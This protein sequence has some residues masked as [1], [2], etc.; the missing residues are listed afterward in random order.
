MSGDFEGG[1]SLRK[2]FDPDRM[3]MGRSR[4]NPYVSDIADLISF[5]PG[6]M[7][8]RKVLRS[9]TVRTLQDG[10]ALFSLLQNIRDEGSGNTVFSTRK[11]PMS[12]VK[13]R[14]RSSPEIDNIIRLTQ[15]FPKQSNI[16]AVP[17]VPSPVDPNPLR[18][19]RDAFI[20]LM[21]GRTPEG[22][23]GRGVQET[24][25][26]G[27]LSDFITR[28]DYMHDES[29]YY[30]GRNDELDPFIEG[31]SALVSGDGQRD[32]Y[33]AVED[34]TFPASAAPSMSGGTLYD[35][36]GDVKIR[37]TM[38]EVQQRLSRH[39]TNVAAPFASH[40]GRP[41]WESHYPNNPELWFPN[42]SR[43]GFGA[44]YDDY[45]GSVLENEGARYMLEE[46]APFYGTWLPQVSWEAEGGPTVTERS[47]TNPES[48]MQ[49]VPRKHMMG[50]YETLLNPV[51]LSGKAQI[52]QALLNNLNRYASQSMRDDIKGSAR[53]FRA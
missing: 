31:M 42:I 1:W 43:Q 37:P 23:K 50:L 45:W 4:E 27:M 29:Y 13:Q 39:L 8:E 46:T 36:T 30:S 40:G 48:W 14:F 47:F 20:D 51:R 12:D 28:P 16:T 25:S 6:S 26:L 7:T 19:D 21:I 34:V 17:L 32:D 41:W 53:G 44:L 52:A 38:P 9:P 15:R 3:V 49:D 35:D 10:A 2:D 18:Y 5:I 22:V 11:D 33:F 24:A